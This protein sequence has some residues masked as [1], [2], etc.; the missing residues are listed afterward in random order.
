MN[1]DQIFNITYDFN[2]LYAQAM[3]MHVANKHFFQNDSKQKEIMDRSV[4]ASLLESNQGWFKL[5]FMF[6]KNIHC[7]CISSK[8]RRSKK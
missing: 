5:N 8:L 1:V 2:N 7:S 4:Q 3:S 6:S